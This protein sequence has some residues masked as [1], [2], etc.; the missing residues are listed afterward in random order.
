[1]A[2]RVGALPTTETAPWR[3]F[4]DGEVWC[5]DTRT[6][7]GEPTTPNK[8][9]QACYAWARRNGFKGTFRTDGDLLYLRLV[10]SSEE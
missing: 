9:R 4:A 6:D 5:L 1:M 3:K 8:A 10:P 7:L 2:E